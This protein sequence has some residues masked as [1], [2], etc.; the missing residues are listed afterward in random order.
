M[1]VIVVVKEVL[2]LMIQHGRIIVVPQHRGSLRLPGL[3]AWV[4]GPASDPH[5]PGE[6]LVR[7]EGL[8]LP[9]FLI[10]LLPFLLQLLLEVVHGFEDL[11]LLHLEAGV[12]HV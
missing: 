1:I 3:N 7:K 9:E 12:G 10:S 2:F 6:A 4:P 8:K 5:H 11:S